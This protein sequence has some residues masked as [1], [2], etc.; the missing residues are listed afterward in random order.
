M[1][2]DEFEK[3]MILGLLEQEEQSEASSP[4]E[5]RRANRRP[6]QAQPT[7]KREHPLE[8]LLRGLRGRPGN[9]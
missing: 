8:T 7:E 9:K 6:G 3:L 5:Q 4:A 2:S 1:K